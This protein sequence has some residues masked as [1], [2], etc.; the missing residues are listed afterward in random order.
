MKYKIFF[1]L[2]PA[3]LL[4]ITVPAQASTIQLLSQR[5]E[6]L[7]FEISLLQSLL[8]NMQEQSDISS[9]AYI[10]QDLKNGSALLQKNQNRP[11]PIASI[12]K[13]MTAVVA[14]ENII[15]GQNIA[16]T[17]EMLRPL[18]QSPSLYLGL[19]VSKENLLKASLI[20]SAN[21]ASEAL[22]FFMG[23]QKF[24]ETMNR[25]AKS[26]GMANTVFY[27]VHGLNPQ[28]TSTA[29]DLAKLVSYIYQNHPEMLN[30]TKNNDFWLAGKTGT[31]L[32]FRN[33]NNFYP[34]S[35]FIGGKTGY[36]P[37]TR[38]T[39]AGVFNVKGQATAV[40]VLYSDNRQADVFSMLL[41]AKN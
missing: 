14:E 17:E 36:L 25:K 39:F 9:P 7:K 21:D 12:T 27:D 28:N 13:L 33:V 26:L 29:S 23:K 1:L 40:V 37:Q 35:D 30:T 16:L 3:S 18:G 24:I 5:I 20:Q 11:Y 34:L 10:A 8:K 32:K 19:S 38:Q 15:P 2:L 31:L 41:T 4:F 6:I 22:A